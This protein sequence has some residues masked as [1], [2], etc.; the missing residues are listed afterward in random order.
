MGHLPVEY[1]VDLALDVIEEV[2]GAVI[3]M[4]HADLLGRR[5]RMGPQPAD[6]GADDRLG[7]LFV[8]VDHPFP[9]V[10]LP[11]PTG[12]GRD[13]LER[14]H[15][16]ELVWIGLGDFAEDGPFALGQGRQERQIGLGLQQHR[17]SFEA[18]DF[19]G[20]EEGV[21]Q[22]ALVLFQPQ[23]FRHR[24]GRAVEGGIGGELHLAL[25]VDQ[26]GRRVAAQDQRLFD[27]LPVRSAIVEAK[28]VGF[29][30][31]AAGDPRQGGDRHIF[32][33]GQAG[34]DIG[35]ELGFEGLGHL[36]FHALDGG[37]GLPHDPH[38]A[39]S[40]RMGRLLGPLTKTAWDC[41]GSPFSVT[42]FRR[43]SSSS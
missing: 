29:A 31:G 25:G 13:R 22:M 2:A 30:R 26:A 16:V 11:L 38:H 17:P 15:Q 9:I 33:A 18:G 36:G 3:A 40:N 43:G 23:H 14:A 10:Q 21:A 32:S 12:V 34:G 20:D 1:A 19:L 37:G 39:I 24:H 6:G 5:R 42:D 4:H 41:F 7:R 35:G 8:L 28:A 27:V